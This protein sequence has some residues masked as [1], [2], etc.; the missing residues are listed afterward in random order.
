M[1]IFPPTHMSGEP[2]KADA[3][4]NLRCKPRHVRRRERAVANAGLLTRTP[5]HA[6]RGRDR[7]VARQDLQKLVLKIIHAVSPRSKGDLR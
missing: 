4:L 7:Q 1:T 6:A 5:H 2:K 3:R